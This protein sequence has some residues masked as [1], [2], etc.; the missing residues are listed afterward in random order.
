MNKFE[1]LIEYVINDDDKKAKALFHSIVVDKSRKIYEGLMDRDRI[2]GDQ[3]DELLNDV[4]AEERGFREDDDEMGMAVDTSYMWY[5]N[6]N[7]LKKKYYENGEI[8]WEKCFEE[9]GRTEME[10][11][12]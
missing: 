8:I 1:K 2:G 6:G 4:E 12:F 3:V 7:V 9:D 5:D 10:C 11:D